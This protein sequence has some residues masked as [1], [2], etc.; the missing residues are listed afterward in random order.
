MR[1]RAQPLPRQNCR[2]AI[3]VLRRPAGL[4]EERRPGNRRS[5]VEREQWNNLVV[6]DRTDEWVASLCHVP[7]RMHRENKSLLE[8]IRDA[9]P[10]LTDD[11][12]GSEVIERY[13]RAIPTLRP[14][15]SENQTTLV[16][17]QTTT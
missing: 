1:T 14:T 17:P 8:C 7:R 5:F 12:R 9:A 6:P 3:V 16:V 13:L 11:E 10:D 2:S 15:G 4:H